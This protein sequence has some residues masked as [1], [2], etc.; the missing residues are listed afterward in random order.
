MWPE[1]QGRSWWLRIVFRPDSSSPPLMAMFTIASLGCTCCKCVFV[2][3]NIQ[4]GSRLQTLIVYAMA[5]V[6]SQQVF[7]HLCSNDRSCAAWQQS[8]RHYS[9]FSSPS[10]ASGAART[11]FSSSSLASSPFWCIEIRM[12]QPPTNSLSTYSWGIVGQS[13][14]SLM[15]VHPC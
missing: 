10:V 9:F 2:S 8:P 13:E 3:S 6:I 15:P 11:V 12:S 14:Y 7:R 1:C 4:Q 5:H